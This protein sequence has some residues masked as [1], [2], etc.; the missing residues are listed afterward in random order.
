MQLIKDIWLS[1]MIASIL[2]SL[3]YICYI[4][5]QI[6]KAIVEQ[7][8]VIENDDDDDDDE[9]DDDNSPVIITRDGSLKSRVKP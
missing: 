7:T 5:T 3:V 9:E 2:F 4:L 6:H 1:V 8:Y